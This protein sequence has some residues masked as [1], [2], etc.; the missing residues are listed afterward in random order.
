MS[1]SGHAS[2]NLEG[3]AVGEPNDVGQCQETGLDLSLQVP[4]EVMAGASIPVAAQSSHRHENGSG[5]W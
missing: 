5:D 4:V 3:L 1:G 2:A